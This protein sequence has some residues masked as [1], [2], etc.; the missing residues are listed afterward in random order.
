MLADF[1]L[2]GSL[3][4]LRGKRPW[5]DCYQGS[6]SLPARMRQLS[7]RTLVLQNIIRNLGIA[8]H[9]V[10]CQSMNPDMPAFY[11]VQSVVYA[12]VIARVTSLGDIGLFLQ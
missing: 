3:L 5:N 11:T 8:Y 7:A 1:L 12:A 9:Q 2:Y 10:C 4:R 6:P